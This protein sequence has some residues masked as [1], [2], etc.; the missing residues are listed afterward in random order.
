MKTCCDSSSLPGLI[1]KPRQIAVEQDEID[2]LGKSGK[3]EVNKRCWSLD[4]GQPRLCI[5]GEE[6]VSKVLA[7]Q[8]RT[9]IGA[10]HFAK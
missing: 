2:I 10:Y 9:L 1:L 8:S 3:R 4:N 5:I 7:F 6:L